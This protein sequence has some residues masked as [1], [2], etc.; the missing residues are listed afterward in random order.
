M[1]QKAQDT[2]PSN[3]N[4]NPNEVMSITLQNGKKLT[5]S[6][7]FQEGHKELKMANED[8]LIY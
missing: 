1:F 2:F 5:N 4:E 7:D 8:D 6:F 3:I